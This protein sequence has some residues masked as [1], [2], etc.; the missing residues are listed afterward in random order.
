MVFP[1]TRLARFSTL[2]LPCLLIACGPRYGDSIAEETGPYQLGTGDELRITIFE[3]PDMSGEFTVDERGELALP[4]IER[5]NANGLTVVELENMIRDALHPQ[6][7]RNPRV[8]AEV[9]THRDV[10]VLGEV[11]DPG[12]YEYVPNMSVLEA[13]A[14][15]GGHTYRAD[16]DSAELIR[17][18]GDKRQLMTVPA[19]ALIR[20]GDTVIIQRRVF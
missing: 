3:Q 8:N 7:L 18:E 11:R 6:Y 20:P 19:T 5:V 14:T 17:R 9:I 12:N 1:L 16:E 13:V 4:L 2:L 10:Y 15:A